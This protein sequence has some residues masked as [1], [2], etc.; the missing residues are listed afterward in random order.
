MSN[1]YSKRAPFCDFL[2]KYQEI[3]K[4]KWTKSM[5][6]TRRVAL[7]RIDEWM[8][9]TQYDFNDINW[10]KLLEFYNFLS[11]QGISPRACMKSIQALKHVV[12]WGVKNGDLKVDLDN[13]YPSKRGDT[14]RWNIELPSQSL[15]FLERLSATRK[16]AYKTHQY[17]HRVIHTFMDQKNLTYKKFRNKQIIQFVKYMDK[18]SLTPLTRLNTLR[19]LKTFFYWLYEEGVIKEHPEDLIPKH[20][21]PK[22]PKGLP[23]PIDP[24]TD[25]RIQD[26]LIKTDD[27]MYKALLLIRRTGMRCKACRELEYDCIVTDS[28]GRTAIRVPAVKVGGEHMVP[29]TKD[30][31]KVIKFLQKVARQN[32][33]KR[34]KPPRLLIN[35]FGRFVRPEP[36]SET[37]MEITAKLMLP[38]WICTHQFR[39]TCATS[40][41]AAGMSLVSVKEILGHKSLNMTLIYAKVVPEKVHNEFNEALKQMNKYKVPKLLEPQ[42][43]GISDSFK[44][45]SKHLRK[46]KDK[47]KSKIKV[48]KVERLLTRLVKI[49]SEIKNLG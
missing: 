35:Q 23:R 22:V 24:E 44:N 25:K 29:I 31:V 11:P 27:Q 4:K 43:T 41:L 6:H 18:K 17:S 16:G 47:S 9:L 5:Y 46:I 8:K 21:M 20:I 45:I 49:K 15:D 42:N 36:F 30:T 19:H 33:K 34:G 7:G 26:L 40:L 28:A 12:S 39:H 32:Y 48:N 3:N 2:E 13:I 1:Q 37:L 38:D 10:F 14:N